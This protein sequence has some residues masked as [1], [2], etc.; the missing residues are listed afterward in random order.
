MLY[1]NLHYLVALSSIE[2]PSRS[3]Q[4]G[5]PSS[6]LRG[7]ELAEGGGPCGL[8]FRSSPLR[9][10]SSPFALLGLEFLLSQWKSPTAWWTRRETA[11]WR[12]KKYSFPLLSSGVFYDLFSI[13]LFPFWFNHP[14]WVGQDPLI[15]ALQEGLDLFRVSMG[16]RKPG[17]HPDR[18]L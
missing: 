5:S 15:L 4:R 1:I 8:R 6:V 3:T 10:I 11:L 13:N 2:S 7:D 17:W 9:P 12:C 18:P 14:P 16:P